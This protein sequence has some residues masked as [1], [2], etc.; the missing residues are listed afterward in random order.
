[1]NF[2]DYNSYISDYMSG[3]SPAAGCKSVYIKDEDT[4]AD[5]KSAPAIAAG[6]REKSFKL[7][8]ARIKTL[9]V[10]ELKKPKAFTSGRP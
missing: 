9:Q 10:A 6:G 7:L 5:A 2:V 4:G 8:V 1:L 3:C